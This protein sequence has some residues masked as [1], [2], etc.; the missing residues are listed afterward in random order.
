MLFFCNMPSFC[1]FAYSTSFFFVQQSNS[2][3]NLSVEIR[4]K[5]KIRYLQNS[6]CRMEWIR[7]LVLLDGRWKAPFQQKI[8][9]VQQKH[10][11]NQQRPTT[12]N[13]YT[14]NITIYLLNTYYLLTIE[15]TGNFRT[16]LDGWTHFFVFLLLF[17]V[18]LVPLSHYRG[19]GGFQTFCRITKKNLS[20]LSTK[21]NVRLRNCPRRR[22]VQPHTKKRAC[23]GRA[24]PCANEF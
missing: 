24:V 14:N 4:K 20:N 16:K 2:P 9:C 18:R 7:L 6:A 17:K 11:Q 1:V 13:K 10:P 3:T 15:Q 23:Q 8:T 12:S 5:L 21:R 19:Y 22:N